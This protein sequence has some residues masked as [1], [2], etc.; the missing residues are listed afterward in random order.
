MM[1]PYRLSDRGFGG[2]EF[3]SSQGESCSIQE[4]SCVDP[5]IWLRLNE[6]TPKLF[7][8]DIDEN[9]KDG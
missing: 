1:K 4:S 7:L 3:E 6:I 8:P 2:Y 9:K 5:S